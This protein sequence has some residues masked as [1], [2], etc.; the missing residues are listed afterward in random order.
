M[1][2]MVGAVRWR[3]CITGL[4]CAKDDGREGRLGVVFAWKSSTFHWPIVTYL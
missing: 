4:E 1:T 3:S 2:K